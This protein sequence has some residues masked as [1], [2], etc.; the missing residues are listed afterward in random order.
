MSLRARI[1]TGTFVLIL[2]TI[3]A[4]G[5]P[6][7]VIV[8]D[9][10][11]DEIQN[12]LKGDAYRTASLVVTAIE[13]GNDRQVAEIADYAAR[14]S[15]SRVT[16]TDR[17]GALIFD[18]DNPDR[19]SEDFANRPEIEAALSGIDASEIRMSET[20]GTEILVVAVP[21][22]RAG[23][24]A[25]ALRLSRGIAEVRADQFKTTASVVAL[26]AILV[27]AGA[28]ISSGIGR[29]VGR[30]VAEIGR[31]AERIGHGEYSARAREVGPPEIRE[32]AHSLNN[33]AAR[34]ETAVSTERTFIGNA[35]HQLKT[36]LAAIGIRLAS[37]S[38]E[39]HLSDVA[40]A[41]LKEAKTEVQDLG[42]LVDQLLLLSRTTDATGAHI[43][44]PSDPG[45]ALRAI[46]SQWREAMATQGIDLEVEIARDLPKISLAPDLL[47]QACDNLLDNV[48]RHCPN[49][50]S[51]LLEAVSEQERLK[52]RVLDTGGGLSPEIERTAFARFTRGT[53]AIPGTGLGLALVRQVAESVGGSVELSTSPAGTEVTLRIPSAS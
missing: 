38:D 26:L 19:A 14:Q 6:L 41:D 5:V 44:E 43:D 29:S 32:L 21:V 36:P 31:V 53:S 28:W 2:L 52:I 9:H 10:A 37:I 35:A 16:V 51:A 23:R 24:I 1:F 15:N 25:G 8:R 7:L 48:T 47:A 18:S 4:L 34:V 13:Q 33:S 22:A 39:P 12:S 42:R 45:P 27:G 17:D 49:S 40:L 3:A 46:A 50:K 11:L 20:L 30:P